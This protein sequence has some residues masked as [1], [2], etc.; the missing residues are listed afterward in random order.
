[1][2]FQITLT[3]FI[4]D[5]LHV[6]DEVT[7]EFI[8]SGYHAIAS[9]WITSGLLTSILT[10]Y[11][12]NFFYQVKYHEMPL[13]EA[14]PHLFKVCFVFALATN[15]DVFYILIFNVVTNEPIAISNALLSK[16]TN[17]DGSL[18]GVFIEGM[19]LAFDLLKNIPLS[20]VG[21]FLTIVGAAL[22][23]AAT[24]LFTIIAVG[25]IV[26]SKFYL[27]VLLALAPY[28]IIAYLFNGS[29]GLTESWAKDVIN[30]ALIPVFVGA[31]MLLTSTLAKACLFAGRASLGS[32]SSPDFASIITYFLCGL[33]SLFLFKII[34]EKTASLTSSLAIA[35]PGKM[36]S[37]AA[38]SMSK[39][40]AAVKAL[41]RGVGKASSEF[42][43]RQQQL[44]GEVRERASTRAEK[45]QDARNARARSGY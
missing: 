3:N 30:K 40:G 44:M 7:A 16:A 36:A 10:L 41:G 23:V 45:A 38:Q 37:Q 39:G 5:I 21:G 2:A 8:Q 4:N 1:M 17:S 11:I 34:P 9:H 26:I 32:S 12:M 33:I 14:T 22:I 20:P 42:K 15:W 18:N 24:V 35:A 29:K 28:F 6:V 19:K 25:L 13:R 27:A 31:V 43:Q